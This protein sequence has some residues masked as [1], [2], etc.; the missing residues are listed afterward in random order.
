MTDAPGRTPAP[1]LASPWA[2]L[3]VLLLLYVAN[4]ADRY[5]ITGLIGPIKAEFAL[6][7][8]LVGLIMG[9]AFVVLYVILGVPLARLADRESRIQIIAA[10][11]AFWSMA[12]FATGLST[13]PVSLSLA[14]V[15]VGIGEAAFVAPAYSLLSDY[16]RP[17]RRGLVFA[18]MGLA[19]YAGQIVGQGGGPAL[20]A[21]AGWRWVFWSMGMLGVALAV[22]AWVTIREPARQMSREAKALPFARLLSL[23]A[24]S[25]AAVLVTA[26]MSFGMVSGVAFGYW[27]PE[28]FTRRFGLDPVTVKATF[29]VNFGLSGLAGT[30]LFGIIADRLTRKGMA[31]PARLSAVSM[32]LATIFILIASHAPDIR[33]VGLLAIPAGAIGGGWS[34]GLLTTIQH[35]FPGSIRAGSTSL[36]LGISTLIGQFAGPFAVGLLSDRLGGDGQALLQALTFIIPFGFL[37]ALCAWIASNHV[38][39]DHAALEQALG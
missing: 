16:F 36:Y 19:T 2:A 22:L 26:S 38:I 35:M 5:L 39:G 21:V 28:L 14:R 8:G 32:G 9:P 31:W 23:F 7:D 6:S 17:E 13:G 33:V 3:G 10:G 4:L 1:S 12:T 29:A 15:A 24:R 37:G 18:I 30:I 20:A 34:V 25:R 11:C 27:A